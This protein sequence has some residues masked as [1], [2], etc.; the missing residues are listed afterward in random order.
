MRKSVYRQSAYYNPL[1][2]T[3]GAVVISFVLLEV[4]RTF[5]RPV[6]GQG[7]GFLPEVL[8]IAPNLL[9][10][11][12]LPLLFVGAFYL[13]MFEQELANT[14]SPSTPTS[15]QR[16]ATGAFLVIATLT[17]VGLILWELAQIGSGLTFDLNDIIATIAGAILSVY[18]YF[19]TRPAVEQDRVRT[20]A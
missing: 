15:A 7:K 3:I 6:Y 1:K 4:L 14:A 2:F 16:P 9:A 10:A 5:V 18:F 8:G 20:K 12:A 19:T 13:V 11:Y 17:T